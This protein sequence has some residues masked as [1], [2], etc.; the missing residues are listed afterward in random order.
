[1]QFAHFSF[2]IVILSRPFG[3][4][5]VVLQLGNPV[6]AMKRDPCFEVFTFIVLTLQFGHFENSVS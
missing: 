4:L 1:M 5:I 6:Q 2:V 3:K